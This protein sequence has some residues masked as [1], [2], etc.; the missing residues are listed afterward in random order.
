MGG[1]RGRPQARRRA[2]G[3]T[4]PADRAEEVVALDQR[5]VGP[6]DELEVVRSRELGRA[7][8]QLEVE[9]HRSP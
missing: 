5:Q 4:G 6:L 8:V 3:L 1:H 7:R 2:A 9:H